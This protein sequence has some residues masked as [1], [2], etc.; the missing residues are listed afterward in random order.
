MSFPLRFRL[1]AS[2][3]A[4]LAPAAPRALLAASA[5]RVLALHGD[6][7]GHRCSSSPTSAAPPRHLGWSAAQALPHP[8]PHACG[9]PL[10]LAGGSHRPRLARAAPVR[11]LRTRKDKKAKKTETAA[12]ATA[13]AAEDGDTGDGGGGG[14]DGRGQ[15]GGPTTQVV[16]L[17]DFTADVSRPP[18]TPLRRRQ[19]A[20][21]THV[22]CPPTRCI[23]SWRALGALASA[24]DGPAAG[25][26]TMCAHACRSHHHARAPPSRL[27]LL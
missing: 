14:G 27:A 18:S 3:A 2:A 15:G 24:A 10:A 9:R 16:A 6:S 4:R 12:G 25:C 21:R 17:Y 13:A 7:G 8:Q 20:S 22:A 11:F 23:L 19:C 5:R 1:G 26:S